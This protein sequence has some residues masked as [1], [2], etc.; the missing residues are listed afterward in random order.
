M[1]QTGRSNVRYVDPQRRYTVVLGPSWNAPFGALPHDDRAG[2]HDGADGQCGS[3]A[4]TGSGQAA[5]WI[6]SKNFCR[7]VQP[8]ESG[9]SAAP[10]SSHMNSRRFMDFSE[11]QQSWTTYNTS[12]AC[13]AA[14][15]DLLCQLWVISRPHVVTRP[16]PLYPRKRTKS[17]HVVMSALCQLRRSD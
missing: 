10:P 6:T 1:A 12:G 7:R 14:K 8:L 11:S 16:C 9:T 13:I 5:M 17:S 2:I 3:Y 4:P 15:A